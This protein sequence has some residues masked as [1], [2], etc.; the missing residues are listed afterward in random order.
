MKAKRLLT[1]MLAFTVLG[2]GAVAA[3]SPW[4]EYK[5]FS[6]VKLNLNNSEV[7]L[8]DVPAFIVDGS[9]VT[10]IRK[11]TDSLRALVNYNSTTGVVDIYNPNVHMFVAEEVLKDKDKDKGPILKNTFGEVKKG[12]SVEF[13][14]FAQVDSLETDIHSFK[15]QIL[16]PQ[17]AVV[18][19]SDDVILEEQKESFWYPWPFKVSFDTVGKYKVQFLMKLKEDAPFTVI[20]EK[21]INCE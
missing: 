21:V 4:G 2:V 20:S 1:L 17:G 10:P 6:K 5:G 14:V 9:V 11:L 18:N 19:S 12:K 8:G 16:D 13:V 15:V 3:G 7:S